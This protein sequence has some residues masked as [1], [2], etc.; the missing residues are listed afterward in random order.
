MRSLALISVG[1][2]L[3]ACG[4][5]GSTDS[6]TIDETGQ[7]SMTMTSSETGSTTDHGS[8][9]STSVSTSDT[10]SDAESSSGSSSAGSSSGVDSSSGSEGSGDPDGVACFFAPAPCMAGD[11][12]CTGLDDVAMCQAADAQCD[13][14]LV[15]CDG[16]E[17]CGDQLCCGTDN[18]G[19]ECADSCTGYH[20]CNGDNDC[21]D[22]ESCCPNGGGAPNGGLQHCTTLE[23]G[24]ECPLPP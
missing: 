22:G 13:G 9:S 17:D 15:A 2:L 19:T 12:C 5:D 11:V 23:Q 10:S 6:T 16:A 20:I 21:N 18:G 7:T 1:A 4:D 8:S 24:Q 3:L 14:V